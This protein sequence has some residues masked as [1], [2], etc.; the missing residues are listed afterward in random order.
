M[1]MITVCSAE[2]EEVEPVA[3]VEEGEHRRIYNERVLVKLFLVL[4]HP[5]VE[6]CV[7][8]WQGAVL[9]CYPDHLRIIERDSYIHNSPTSPLN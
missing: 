7:F 4:S 3:D 2:N 8:V 5:L 9:A 6:D 1:K